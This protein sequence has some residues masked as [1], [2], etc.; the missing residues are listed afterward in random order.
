MQSNLAHATPE[1]KAVIFDLDG[2]LT[3]TSIFHGTAWAD[4]VR[5]LGYEPPHDLE[6]KVKGISRMASLKIALGE[7]AAKYTP[8]QLEELATKKNEFYQK[9]AAGITPANLF[10]GVL[11]LFNDLKKNGI[12]VVLGSASKNSKPVLEKLGIIGYFDAIADGFTYTHGKPHPDVFWTGA[13]M[14]GATASECIV[15]EDASAGIDAAIDGGFVAVGMGNYESLKHAHRYIKSLTEVNAVEMRHTHAQ[16]CQVLWNVTRTGIDTKKERSLNTLFC[17]GN[18]HIGVRGSV[19]ELLNVHDSGQYM[20]G[21]FDILERSAPPPEQWSP[22]LKYWGVPELARDIQR[23]AY[24]V[25][26]PDILEMQWVVDGE[27][28]DLSTGTVIDITRQLDMRLGIFTLRTHWRSPMGKELLLVVRRFADM[29]KPEMVRSQYEVEPLN[30]SGEIIV[31]AGITTFT[32]N[33]D[34]KNP[35]CLYTV[36]ATATPSTQIAIASVTGK[37]RLQKAVFGSKITAGDVPLS[38]YTSITEDNFIGTEITIAAKKNVLVQLDRVSCAALGTKSAADV[39]TL[40]SGEKSYPVARIEH[41]ARWKSLWNNSDIIIEGTIDDQVAIRHSLFNLLIAGPQ[42]TDKVSIAAKSLSGEGYRGMVFWDTDI[43]MMPFFTFTQPEIARNLAM[44]RYS[45]LDGA[46]RKAQKY[47]HK[48]AWY[49]WET[50]V[51]GDEECEKWLKLITHQSHIVGDI[52]YAL[53]LYIDTTGDTEFYKKCAAEIY[54]ETARF[55]VSKAVVNAGGDV[56][57]PDAGGPDEYHVVSHD[58]AYVNNLARYNL[59]LAESAIDFLTTKESALWASLQKKIGI[60]EDEI[61]QIRA[62]KSKIKTMQDST[63]LIEECRDFFKLEDRIEHDE[64]LGTPQ[65]TQT[66]KQA[67]VMMLLYLFPDLFSKE[68]VRKNWD[69]YEPRTVHASSLSHGVHGILAAELGMSEKASTYMQQTFGMDL[70][71]TMNNTAG[72]AHM[73]A[74]GLNWQAVV[75]GY[76][77]GRPCT[78]ESGSAYLVEPRLPSQWTRLCYKVKWHGATLTVDIHSDSVFVGSDVA[79]PKTVAVVLKGKTHTLKPGATVCA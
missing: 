13:K 52:V 72:G 67:D 54:I 70:R 29:A 42:H 23:E 62:Y 44:F 22:F 66:I 45:T 15:V 19:A 30:F 71:D 55:W 26:C 27:M 43:H 25:R 34:R 37:S 69:Y 7:H 24:L 31:R 32:Q 79:S 61:S 28:I 17:V 68:V 58:S 35:Q 21:F 49:P 5:S 64:K 57:I 78:T 77:G 10:P 59:Q 6:E 36:N 75:R 38:A 51:S 14:V 33:F 39:A 53:S 41:A 11:D 65:T 1:L 40:L 60:S 18:G 74:N 20:A 3:D 8:E 73:A 76:G 56:S 9:L 2:V 63:G 50:G 4:L 46:R 12:K 48:G 16:F 47:G